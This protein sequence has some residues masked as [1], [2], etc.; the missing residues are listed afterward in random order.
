MNFRNRVEVEKKDWIKF[1]EAQVLMDI[2]QVLDGFN[3]ASK[4]VPE[5]IK[6]NQWV[7]GIQNIQKQFENV[8][9]EKG[10]EK[11]ACL[12]QPFDPNYH[13]AIFKEESDKSED[14]ILEIF[15]DG[16]KLGDKVIRPAR[17]K[18]AKAR[19]SIG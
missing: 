12:G 4:H 8:L 15:A 11:I 10:V 14:T 19:E 3:Q 9:K 13:E 16:Y 18:V 5:D 6:D 2:V 7:Q 17:V 1:G